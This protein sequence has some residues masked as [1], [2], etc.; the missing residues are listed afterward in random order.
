VQIFNYPIHFVTPCILNRWKNY[1]S[2]LE[3]TAVPT[4][5]EVEIAIEKLKSYKLSG[6]DQITAEFI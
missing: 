1:L 2:L 4:S 3:Y 5:C 6:I